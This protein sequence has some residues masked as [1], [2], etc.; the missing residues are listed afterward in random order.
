M[1]LAAGRAA[2]M[3]K[4]TTATGSQEP[5]SA[6][7]MQAIRAE[8]DAKMVIFIRFMSNRDDEKTR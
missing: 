8:P 2:M 1:A 6:R 7:D 5:F 4:L 3:R